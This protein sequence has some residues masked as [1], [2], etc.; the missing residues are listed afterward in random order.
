MFIGHMTIKFHLE[1]CTSLK[2]KR[3][4]LSIVKNHFGKI[5]NIALAETDSQDSLKIAVITFVT[6]ANVK[7][8]VDKSLTDIEKQLDILI[9]D[10][11]ILLNREIL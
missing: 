2:D 9:P 4:R 10:Y 3:H 8:T 5:S 1:G 6:I 7:N 11:K